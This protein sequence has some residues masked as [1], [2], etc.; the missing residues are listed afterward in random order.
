MSA[1]LNI[2]YSKNREED[3]IDLYI[4][5]L[6]ALNQSVKD[7]MYRFRTVAQVQSDDLAFMKLRMPSSAP[8]NFVKQV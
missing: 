2:L 7:C 5:L 3:C 1:Y 4:D 6:S 8:Q